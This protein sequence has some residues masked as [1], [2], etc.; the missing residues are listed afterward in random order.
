MSGKLWTKQT[1]HK[2]CMHELVCYP[3][4]TGQPPSGCDR[5]TF[6]K[7]LDNNTL[8]IC[9]CFMNALRAHY[10]FFWT[11]RTV[12]W[13]WWTHLSSN[14]LPSSRHQACTSGL[15][16]DTE[17][18]DPKVSPV[19][20]TNTSRQLA[21]PECCPPQP[22]I[23]NAQSTGNSLDKLITKMN[24]PPTVQWC[25]SQMHWLRIQP[26]MTRCSYPD[27]NDFFQ[28]EHTPP[29]EESLM[30][31]CLWN[32]CK[33]HTTTFGVTFWTHLSDSALC[34]RHQTS[35]WGE[36]FWK[37][38]V[39]PSSWVQRFCKRSVELQLW[40]PC[41]SLRHVFPLICHPSLSCYLW[42]TG[43]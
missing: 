8:Y 6:M 43:K 5:G 36:L 10:A 1:K 9:D 18:Y 22:P 27:G 15:P 19:T 28:D 34:R 2:F 24:S 41:T 31:W 21:K 20:N 14:V 7:R 13:M 17:V 39:Y 3:N 11:V 37:D 23:P 30:L 40:S 33:L 12:L 35:K 26:Q 32:W 29:T 16:K 4:S 25:K 38:D 42:Q